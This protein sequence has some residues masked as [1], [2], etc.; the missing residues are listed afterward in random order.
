MS[1]AASG[2]QVLSVSGTKIGK[3]YTIFIKT[4]GNSSAVSVEYKALDDSNWTIAQS[5][6]V[7][8]TYTTRL[9]GDYEFRVYDGETFHNAVIKVFG[10]YHEM[11]AK[12]EIGY[13]I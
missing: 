13:L 11:A 8:S 4:L 1:A 6:F 2:T 9:D 7:G 12:V 10:L 3:N 5:A